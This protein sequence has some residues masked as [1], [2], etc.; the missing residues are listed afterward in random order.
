MTDILSARIGRAGAI[1][2][3]RPQ[4]HNALTLPMITTLQ[5]A[6]DNFC[7]DDVVQQ[8]VISSASDKA[9]CAGGD[10]RAATAQRGK[11][12]EG[13]AFFRAEYQLNHAIAHAA[14]PVV[15]LVD[16]ICMGGGLG[17]ACH[18]QYCVTTERSVWAMPEMAIGLFPDIGAGYFLNKCPPGVGLWLALTG[19][20]LSGAQAVAAG[21]A[22]YLVPAADLAEVQRRLTKEEAEEVLMP[23]AY[24]AVAALADPAI[25]DFAGIDK[26]EKL[27]LLLKKYPA[28]Q[29]ASPTSLA[30]TVQHLAA[31]KGLSLQAVLRRDYRLACACLRGH[32]FYEGVRAMLVDKDKNPR[33]QP[34]SLAEVTQA[35]LD[36]H[37]ATPLG[38]D[39]FDS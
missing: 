19:A 11:P 10:V 30:L 6:L 33:W 13:A 26:I 32:D 12:E 8:I 2:L 16:G 39:L 25:H 17:L 23:Y 18:A 3:N 5:Q 7:V 38:P 22:Q 15:A 9:F 24:P 20:R 35:Q 27:S 29:A 21:L 36:A 14:K 1:T 34:A 31:C 37:L 28:L 4:A